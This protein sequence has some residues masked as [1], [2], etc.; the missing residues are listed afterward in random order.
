MII[1]CEKSRDHHIEYIKSIG[2]NPCKCGNNDLIAHPESQSTDFDD[3]GFP[4]IDDYNFIQC[5][6]CGATV[7]GCGKDEIE[8]WNKQEYDDYDSGALK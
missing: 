7:W 3:D 2:I 4:V 5:K 1:V 6:S 8:Q